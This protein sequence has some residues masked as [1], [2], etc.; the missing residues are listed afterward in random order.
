MD[1]LQI[2]YVVCGVMALLLLIWLRSLSVKRPDKMAGGISLGKKIAKCGHKTKIKGKI[3]AFGQ[4]TITKMPVNKDGSVDYCLD[5]IGKM[6]IRCAWCKEPIFIGDIITLYSPRDKDKFTLPENAVIY[7][8]E[9]MSV[10]GCGRTTCAD[11]GADYAGSW[12]PDENGKGKVH[13]RPTMIEQ[14]MAN[15]TEGGNGV[16]IQNH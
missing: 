14:S 3:T 15:L 16:I 9:R 10:V 1:K 6:A 2:V 13:R 8:E 5:C 11:T 12:I 4:T 7:N